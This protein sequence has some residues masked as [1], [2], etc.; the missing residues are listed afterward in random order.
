M[1]PA[2][3]TPE[4]QLKMLEKGVSPYTQALAAIRDKADCLGASQSLL[5]SLISA[6]PRMTHRSSFVSIEN[7]FAFLDCEGGARR[8]QMWGRFDAFWRSNMS[9]YHAKTPD[10][11]EEQWAAVANGNPPRLQYGSVVSVGT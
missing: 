9:A 8:S 10:T 4:D 6:Y 5:A 3:P 2:M 1:D 7:G 11:M